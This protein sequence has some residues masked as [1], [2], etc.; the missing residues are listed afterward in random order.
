M[1][2]HRS[3]Q[4]ALFHPR[5]FHT[6]VF[7]D[8]VI[9]D[10]HPP[11]PNAAM[12]SSLRRE[13]WPSRAQ[14]EIGFKKA[15]IFKSFDRRFLPAFLAHG[16]KDL[17]DGSVVLT[18]PKAQEAWSFIRSQFHPV[19]QDT[20]TTAARYRERLIN[21]EFVPFQDGGLETFARGDSKQ[22][23]MSL[24]SLRPRAFYM[25]GKH[26]HINTAE[27]RKR[28]LELTGTGPGGNGGV[29]DGGTEMKVI[30][31]TTHF[32]CF[33]TPIRVASEIS[34]WLA[35]EMIRW[36]VEREFWAQLDTGK[37]KNDKKELSEKWIDMVKRGA[38]I[39]RPGASTIAKL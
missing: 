29:H 23:L 13:K 19:P 39:S 24:P 26:S 9:A 14:A 15:P 35:K 18:T 25:F 33:E 17:E 38:S 1:L 3:A 31:K 30:E 16:L 22:T 4:L 6:L 27:Q 2:I 28:L 7:I 10:A 37:S 36:Q 12:L 32:L 34:E 11:G 5:L 21:P 8:P 20:N